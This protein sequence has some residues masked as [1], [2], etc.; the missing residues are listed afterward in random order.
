MKKIRS[1]QVQVKFPGSYVFFLFFFLDFMK[2]PPDIFSIQVKSWSMLHHDTNALR[3]ICYAMAAIAIK[4]IS[5][6]S[7]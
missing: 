5:T 3:N 6:L 4:H 1:P 2:L 7:E